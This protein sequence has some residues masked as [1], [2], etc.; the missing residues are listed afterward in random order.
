MTKQTIKE[1]PKCEQK[2]LYWW[3]EEVNGEDICG[4]CRPEREVKNE[5]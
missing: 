2:F 3:F 5:N 1:C 4:F